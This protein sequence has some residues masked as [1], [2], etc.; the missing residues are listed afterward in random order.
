MYFDASSGVEVPCPDPGA[1]LYV[2][3]SRGALARVSLPPDCL[4]FQIGET[5]QVHSGGALSATP[6]CVRAPAPGPGRAAVAR[7]ALAVFME[8]E[9][10]A[11]MAA[12]GGTGEEEVR[13]GARGA[14]LPPGVA[15]LDSRW[16]G[17]A[18]DFGA[19]TTATLGAYY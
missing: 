15:T 3:S 2:R 14:L 1:G 9:W 4:A 18:Q 7:A 5:A 16:E 8:P 19:F 11:P 17:G 10:S 6:H 12:P 13:A